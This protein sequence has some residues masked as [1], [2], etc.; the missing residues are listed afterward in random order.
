[1][2]F[3]EGLK[4]LFG[5]SSKEKNNGSGLAQPALQKVLVVEDED[6][7]GRA[8]EM[9]LKHDGFDVARAG[10]GQIGYDLAQTFLP[11]IILADIM[12]PVM[13]GKAMLKKLRELPQFKSTP[14]IILTNAGTV[15]NMEEAK[16][17]SGASDFLIKSNVNLDEVAAKIRMLLPRAPSEG[18]ATQTNT[19]GVS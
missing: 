9:K 7:L 16:L 15:E 18:S 4:A 19:P 1:M 5:N 6:M 17:V 2:G 14:A 13:D 8:L 3:F 10:N 11:D 12:M